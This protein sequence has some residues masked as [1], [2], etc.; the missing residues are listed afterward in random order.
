MSTNFKNRI[1]IIFIFLVS[2]TIFVNH[3]YSENE[4]FLIALY[5]CLVVC[6][7]HLIFVNSKNQYLRIYFKREKV[8]YYTSLGLVVLIFILWPTKYDLMMREALNIRKDHPDQI[9]FDGEKEPPVPSL[10]A[11]SP[12]NRGVD[13][14]KNEIRDDVDIWINRTGENY[15]ERMAMR[16]YARSVEKL[17]DNCI[18]KDGNNLQKV[19]DEWIMAKSCQHELMNKV[20]LNKLSYE[21]MSK[22]LYGN[23]LKHCWDHLNRYAPIFY[24][25][26][27][28]DN[29]FVNCMFKVEN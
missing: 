17:I 15:N 16:Q 13:L 3:F 18:Q 22:I 12:R 7:L 29:P 26:H 11:I 14:N 10:I 19:I 23:H 6:F 2:F 21:E 1:F 8:V 27:S 5:S 20:H 9:V 4:S 28:A 24:Y 25:N